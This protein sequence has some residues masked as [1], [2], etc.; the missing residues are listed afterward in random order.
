MGITLFIILDYSIDRFMLHGVN[1]FYGLNQDSEILIIGHSHIMLA[2]DKDRLEKELS[3]KVSKYT[4]EGV[5]V[6]DRKIMIEQFL[7]TNN[8]DSLKIVLYGVDLCTFTG[9][10]LS[11]NSY[12]LFYPFMN[13]HNTSEYVYNSTDAL[14]YWLHKLLRTHRYNDDGIKNG[15]LRGWLNNWSNMKYGKVDIE[16][17]K[18]RLVAGN[19]RHIQ[20]NS[21]LIK[22]FKE[23]ID[24]LTSRGIKVIL[25]N[26]PTLDLLNDF[27]PE[28][29]IQ[30]TNWFESFAMEN[31][32]IEYWD[33]N[34][35]YSSDY[36]L[37]Y[38]RLHLNVDG[39]EVITEEL[40]KRLIIM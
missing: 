31:N 2:T 6:S 7:N 33:F 26:T 29:F 10:G 38:D 12:K 40:I 35:M 9:E 21:E 11:E 30:M 13:D 16:K 4:R 32:L 27:E 8:C 20:M 3:V 23:S 14:D 28:K 25:I 24:M 22:D 34:P 15:A 1:K 19:E 17:Y 36:N 37:F 39:Q 5:N 18:K